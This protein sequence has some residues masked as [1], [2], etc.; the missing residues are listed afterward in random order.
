MTEMCDPCPRTPVTYVPSLYSFKL[1]H[2]AWGE[3]GCGLGSAQREGTRIAGWQSSGVGQSVFFRGLFVGAFEF[4]QVG[5]QLVGR[6]PALDVEA[7]HFV[8]AFGRLAAGPE[9]D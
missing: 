2:P 4:R 6:G 1:G 5:F 9:G 7:E 8:R 3:R